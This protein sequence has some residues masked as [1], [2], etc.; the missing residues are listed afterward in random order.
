M[1]SGRTHG[2]FLPLQVLSFSLLCVICALW[3]PSQNSMRYA[4]SSED[5]D[6]VFD[7]EDILALIKQSSLRSKDAWNLELSYA[8]S[9]HGVARGDLEEET[10][11]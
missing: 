5:A 11:S 10:A 1:S 2:S 4:Y 7:K 9:C 6:E 3:A 8:E